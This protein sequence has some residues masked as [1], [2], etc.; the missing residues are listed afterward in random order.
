LK[1]VLERPEVKQALEALDAATRPSGIPAPV[2]GNHP[3][4]SIAHEF[5]RLIGIGNAVSAFRSLATPVGSHEQEKDIEET[6]FTANLPP[7]LQPRKAK[8]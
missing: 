5:Y 1:E 6:A 2:P 7:E 8:P 4:T 3:D